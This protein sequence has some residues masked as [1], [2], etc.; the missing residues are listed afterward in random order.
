[1]SATTNT[2]ASSTVKSILPYTYGLRGVNPRVDDTLK[3]LL[4]Y[5]IGV[6]CLV[7]LIG[8]AWQMATAHLRHLLNLGASPPRQAYWSEDTSTVW[9][10]LKV[11]LLYA[12][13]HKKRH[14]KE[15]MLSSAVNVGTLPSRLH[16]IIL[17]TYLLTNVIYCTYLDYSRPTAALLAELRGRTGFL[18]IV[19]M[20]L[21][22]ILAARNNPFNYLLGVSFDTY[23]KFHRWI[24]RVVV[25]QAIVHTFAWASNE[26]AAKGHR[27]KP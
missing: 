24:G 3:D 16:T 10:K 13:L 21:L 8:R 7:I 15:I 19:N 11:H 18:S 25:T 26:Y 6:V 4:W 20:V 27:G 14:N 22:I 5:S 2:S 17:L 1:M 12:P 9:P 23:N